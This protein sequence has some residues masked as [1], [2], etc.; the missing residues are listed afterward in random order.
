MCRQI[1]NWKANREKRW[2]FIWRLTCEHQLLLQGMPADK[3]D[4]QKQGEIG[5]RYRQ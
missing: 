2:V 3:E 4:D 1:E 5:D